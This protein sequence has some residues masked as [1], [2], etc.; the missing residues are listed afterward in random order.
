MQMGAFRLV[1]ALAVGIAAIIVLAFGALAIGLFLLDKIGGSGPAITET[2]LEQGATMITLAVLSFIILVFV[3]VAIARVLAT[4]N[5]QNHAHALGLP[6]GSVRAIIAMAFLIFLAVMSVF[7]IQT[8]KGRFENVGQALTET[9]SF[10]GGSAENVPPEIRD[11]LERQVTVELS[12][13]FAGDRPWRVLFDPPEVGGI[14]GAATVSLTGTFQEL[15]EQSEANELSREVLT[16]I[17]TA[18]TAIVGFYFGSRSMA[19][20]VQQTAA[21][22]TGATALEL[23][24]RRTKNRLS[25]LAREGGIVERRFVAL[26][27]RIAAGTN[28]PEGW[29]RLEGSG[30][31]SARARLEEARATL[32]KAE[33][34]LLR[35]DATKTEREAL[36]ADMRR[37]IDDLQMVDASLTEAT[38]PGD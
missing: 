26:R 17:A 6:A 33:A 25:D 10:A 2:A 19:D 23:T 14:A 20:G 32:G 28:P 29:S 8:A 34:E 7:S 35:T 11:E 15:V 31:D 24:V 4:A 12:E 30:P 9:A 22:G 27:D 38:P 37:A 5:L 21:D 13:R 36:L 1:I 16:I 18:L 3:L